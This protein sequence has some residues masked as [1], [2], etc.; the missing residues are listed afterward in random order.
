M[1]QI[2]DHGD[3]M[4]SEQD[5][6]YREHAERA[7]AEKPPLAP[8]SVAALGHILVQEFS[9]SQIDRMTIEQRWLKDLRQYKGRYEPD[10]EAA[11]GS[12]S[13]TFIR[14]TRV[15][16]KTADSRMMDLLFPNGTERNWSVKPTPR[17][18][19]PDDVLQTLQQQAQALAQQSGQTQQAA[20]EQLKSDYASKAAAEMTKTIA[21]Q[22]AEAKYKSV[23]SKVLHSGNLYGTGVMKGPLLERRVRTSYAPVMAGKRL[24]WQLKS[25]Q[26]VVPTVVHVSLFNF[27]PDMSSVELNGCRFVFELHTMTQADLTEL[28]KRPSF[29][30]EIIENYIKTN[31]KGR[32][33][34]RNIEQQ[35]RSVGDLVFDGRD[36]YQWDVLER[37]GWLSGE[38][39]RDAGVTVPEDR[40]TEVFFSNVWMLPDG[41]IIKAKL[42]KLSGEA[43]WPYRLYY[44]EKDEDSIFG[45]GLAEVMRDDQTNINAGVRMMLDNGAFSAGP[46]F[47]VDLNQVSNATDATDIRPWKVW[48]KKVT[49]GGNNLGDPIKMFQPNAN[50]AGL[51]QLVSM[52]DTNADE[53]TALPRYMSGENVTRGAGGTASGMS[54][55]MAAA[56]VVL[57]DLLNSWDDGISQPMVEGFYNWNMRY[58]PDASIK[59]D[60]N[61]EARGASSLIAKEVR[62]LQLEKF[63]QQ[64]N[65]PDDAKF[66][67]RRKALRE[68]ANCNEMNDVMYSDEEVERNAKSPEAQQVQQLQ[69]QQ[70]QMAMQLQQAQTQ[71]LLADAQR[72]QASAEQM[73]A[74][75]ELVV[76]KAVETRVNSIYIAAQAG[77]TLLQ[78]PGAA[79]AADQVFRSAGGRD[80]QDQRSQNTQEQGME[81]LS[82]ALQPADAGAQTGVQ[83]DG[84]NHPDRGGP[85]LPAPATP[86]PAAAGGADGARSGVET[87]RDDGAATNG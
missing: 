75:I 43:D 16:V 52:F 80:Q 3:V 37:W 38:Q 11:M 6:E 56:N 55:L 74:D 47:M 21:D 70:Q 61:V 40:M 30:S 22:L 5:A 76:E 83:P 77:Q 71:K 32:V 36:T 50:L 86:L 81:L 41:Q 72:A 15:K 13:K 79:V 20:L 7:Y 45:N 69:Q 18:T 53:V 14:K 26:Y 66:V 42:S 1:P 58:N 68:W 31:P 25:V 65:N 67:N 27:Y 9:R 60:F 34:M 63:L 23:C 85:A 84:T 24:K 46:Q 35:K 78:N 4:Q 54:M 51:G 17:P 2:D 82:Q 12:R 59:G 28:R 64:T 8:N 33:L 49:A 48:T 57:K 87:A 73:K 29:N 19:L 10:E 39:L 62:G 44:F